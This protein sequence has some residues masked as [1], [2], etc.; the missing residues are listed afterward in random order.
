MSQTLAPPRRP[1]ARRR[2]T[3]P[4]TLGYWTGTLVG[5]LGLALVGALVVMTVGRMSDHIDAFP[6]TEIPGTVTVGLD[7]STGRTI[8][9]EG[10][11]PLPLTALDLHVTDPNGN[12]VVVRPYGLELRYD[13]PGF[14][15]AV[16]YAIGTFRTTIG[17]SYRMQAEGTA[18]PGTT[19]AV[20]D[21]FATSIVGYALGAFVVLLLTIGGALALVIATAVRRSTARRQGFLDDDRSDLLSR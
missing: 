1:D 17:G 7:A 14:P 5:I 13:V 16:G 9:V 3:M 11:A 6:R 21:S 15:G 2:D 18:P 8:Y 10:L 20:G 4:S 12:E 19:L